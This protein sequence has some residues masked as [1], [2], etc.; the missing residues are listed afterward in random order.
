M[1][2]LRKTFHLKMRILLFGTQNFLITSL[3]LH[4]ILRKVTFLQFFFFYKLKR[5]IVSSNRYDHRV[6]F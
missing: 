4:I 3:K 5:R 1:G 2:S 6:K